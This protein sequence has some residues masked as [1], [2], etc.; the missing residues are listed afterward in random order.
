MVNREGLTDNE[1]VTINKHKIDLDDMKD[2]ICLKKNY[3]DKVKQ[4]DD[5]QKKL[6][7][8][9]KLNKANSD[10]ASQNSAITG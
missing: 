6:D 7:Q 8:M 10:Q 9:K 5:L 1:S 3:D 2:T 4:V